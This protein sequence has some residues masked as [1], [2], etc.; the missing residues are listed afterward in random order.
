MDG[1]RKRVARSES[2]G[3][4]SYPFELCAERFETP[5]LFAKAMVGDGSYRNP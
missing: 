3:R 2:A 5:G 4:E 1:R